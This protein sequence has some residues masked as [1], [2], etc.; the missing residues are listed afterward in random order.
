MNKEENKLLACVHCGLCLEA[1]PTYVLTGNENDSPRGRIYLMR[2][3]EEGRIDKESNAFERHINRCMGCR[4]C[5]KACPAGV[6][7][8]YL[9]ESARAKLFHGGKKR[10]FSNR[11][12]HTIL[13]HIWPY[14]TR[15]HFVLSI[16]K[17]MRDT[18]IVKLLLKT[19]IPTSISSKL[20][21]ALTLLDCSS[22]VR[23]KGSINKPNIKPSVESLPV[24]EAMLFTGCVMSS[25]F[26]HVNEATK[27]VLEINNCKT[28]VPTAQVCCG[29]LHAHSGDLEQAKA[30]ARRNI[31]AFS[32]NENKPIITNAGGCGAMLYSYGHLLADDPDYSERAASFSKRIRDIGQQIKA[33]GIQLGAIVPV[34]TVT[35]DTSCHL[36]YGQH[37]SEESLGMLKLIPEIEFVPLEGSEMCCGGAGIYNLLETEM[38]TGVLNEKLKHIKD[39]NAQ[40]LATGNP[41]CHMQIA[42]GAQISGM[43]GLRVCHPVELL[44]ESYRRAGLYDKSHPNKPSSAGQEQ[45]LFF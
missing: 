7:Y 43:K 8:G 1:C 19:H 26:S 18:G 5:E 20:G 45:G 40:I 35:Y 13:R 12:L 34:G 33:V 38:S 3:V 2:G 10:S 6:E 32:D 23:F 22:P 41:G 39:T 16:T 11:L 29:A 4:A 9:L 44:D 21:L 28:S 42:A 30:M 27:R 15:L 17:L 25:L 36:I 37:A 14:P 24:S 31:D